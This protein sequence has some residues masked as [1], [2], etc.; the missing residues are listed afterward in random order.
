MAQGKSSSITFLKFSSSQALH[1]PWVLKSPPANTSW[2]WQF[3]RDTL[4]PSHPTKWHTIFVGCHTPSPSLLTGS[5]QADRRISG[6][7]HLYISSDSCL[8]SSCFSWI[9]LNQSTIRASSD[10]STEETKGK[11]LHQFSPPG[12][13]TQSLEGEPRMTHVSPGNLK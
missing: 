10:S 9:S 4:D 13:N 6:C 8:S 1:R 11:K 5:A 2:C 3:S 12:S 7:T